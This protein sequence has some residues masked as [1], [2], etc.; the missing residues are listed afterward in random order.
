MIVDERRLGYLPVD[1]FAGKWMPDE[2]NRLATAV[3]E[4]TGCKPGEEPEKRT[5]K[6]RQLFGATCVT[7]Q[8]TWFLRVAARQFIPV[9]GPPKSSPSKCPH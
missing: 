8:V 9:W 5:D 1:D 6:N 2:E 4:L 3:Y 7:M